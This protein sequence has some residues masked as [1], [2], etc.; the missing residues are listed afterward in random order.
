MYIN[1]DS[2][3]V[4]GANTFKVW[5]SYVKSVDVLCLQ[6]QRLQI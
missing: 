5:P 6:K 1:K 4:G 2:I 3:P